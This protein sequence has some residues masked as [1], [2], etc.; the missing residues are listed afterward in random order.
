MDIDGI[1][2]ML[3]PLLEAQSTAS[4]CYGRDNTEEAP[5]A[6]ADGEV[7]QFVSIDNDC[8]VVSCI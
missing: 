6:E 8:I 3:Y 7:S 2:G 4:R 1:C 5:N